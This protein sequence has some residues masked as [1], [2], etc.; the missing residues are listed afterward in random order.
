M[1]A[2]GLR[3][4]V[5]DLLRGRRP[6]GF[7]PDDFEA[8]QMRTAIDLTVTGA[9]ADAPRDE[10]LGDLHRRLAAQLDETAP[11]MPGPT[12]LSANRRQVHMVP[13]GRLANSMALSWRS[14]FGRNGNPR[15]I[16]PRRRA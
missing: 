8:A 15:R 3:R 14:Y 10:F 12:W 5:E 7:T 1:N 2:R 11:A 9:D 6:K 16:L 4:Y 13:V